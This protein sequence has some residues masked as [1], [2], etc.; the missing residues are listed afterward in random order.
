MQIFRRVRVFRKGR[1]VFAI[2]GLNY[3]NYITKL[4]KDQGEMTS[5]LQG[6][7][8]YSPDVAPFY[9]F[10]TGGQNW[11]REHLSNSRLWTLKSP[12]TF[13]PHFTDEPR[14]LIHSEAGISLEFVFEVSGTCINVIQSI[15]IYIFRP[16]ILPLFE[17]VQHQRQSW[18]SWMPC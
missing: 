12:L 6:L 7:S 14:S 15:H 10:T 17:K 9:S 13:I 16:M 18:L 1:F 11:R 3:I 4:T 8:G 2:D 5:T